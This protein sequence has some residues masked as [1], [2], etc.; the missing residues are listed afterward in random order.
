[1]TQ[2]LL[3]QAR[4]K[5]FLL[6]VSL[7][8]LIIQ[9]GDNMLQDFFER[10]LQNMIEAYL[11]YRKSVDE[12]FKNWLTLE[13]ELSSKEKKQIRSHGSHKS[14][15]ENLHSKSINKETEKA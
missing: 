8:H 11:K 4:C 7:L 15:L 3:E 1:L 12:Q 10:Y 5:R 14:F 13:S 9:Y 2:I 6:P